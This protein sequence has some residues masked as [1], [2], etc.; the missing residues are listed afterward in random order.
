MTTTSPRPRLTP[1]QAEL[2]KGAARLHG[3]EI[4][5]IELE[6]EFWKQV[7]EELRAVRESLWRIADEV[8]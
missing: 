3:L 7:V 1:N 4:V 8:A 6:G 5:L 2:V